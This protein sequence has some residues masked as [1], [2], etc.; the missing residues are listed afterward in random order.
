MSMLRSVVLGCGSYL[1][2]R[3]VTNDELAKTVE[4]FEKTIQPV[5]GAFVVEMSKSTPIKAGDSLPEDVKAKIDAAIPR[6]AYVKP[7]KPRKMRSRPSPE[8]RL[9]DEVLA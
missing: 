8:R 4:A 3:V 7:K 2:S 1:P 6:T 9:F 5:L